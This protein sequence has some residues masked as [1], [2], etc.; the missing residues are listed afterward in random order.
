V[1][2]DTSPVVTPAEV[3][4]KEMTGPQRGRYMAKVVT[5]KMKALFQAYDPKH[6]AKF[7]CASCHGKSAKERKFKMPSPELPALAAS[8]EVFMATTM[9]EKPE[10]VK[11]MGEKVTPLMAQLL[12]RPHFDHAKPD[13]TAFSCT[14]CHTLKSE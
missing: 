5:P 7:D 6:F 14:G 12:G 11:F 1:D 10:M 4:W 9:K 8:P 2:Q 3:P 13:P